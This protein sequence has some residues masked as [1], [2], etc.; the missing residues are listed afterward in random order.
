[1]VWFGLGGLPGGPPEAPGQEGTLM[2][3]GCLPGAPGPGAKTTK[4]ILA[5]EIESNLVGILRCD[6]SFPGVGAAGLR[7][8]AQRLS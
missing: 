4:L 6:C 2:V 5:L 8:T 3:L 7:R 1:M